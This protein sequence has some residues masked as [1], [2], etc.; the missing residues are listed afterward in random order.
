MVIRPSYSDTAK[1]IRPAQSD[2]A[3]VIQLSYSDSPIRTRPSHSDSA[4]SFGLGH[5]IRIRP[6]FSKD[7]RRFERD[8]DEFKL[9]AVAFLHA[10]SPS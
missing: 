3:K 4:I 7:R 1:A 8:N 9:A 2:S 6:D 5:P 10:T